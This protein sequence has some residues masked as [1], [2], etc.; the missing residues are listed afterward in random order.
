MLTPRELTSNA[1]SLREEYVLIWIRV[2]RAAYGQVVTR[3]VDVGSSRSRRATLILWVNGGEK[4]ILQQ[5]PETRH[6]ITS[7]DGGIIVPSARCECSSSNM[8][9]P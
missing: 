4:V 7:A 2:Y 1:V 5:G 6:F 3:R 9:F 8:R